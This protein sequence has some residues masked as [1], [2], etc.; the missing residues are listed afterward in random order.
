MSALTRT[1]YLSSSAFGVVLGTV[2]RAVGVSD[3]PVWLGAVFLGGIA[4]C[5][6][7][8]LG[9]YARPEP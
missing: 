4:S 5:A 2:D 6:P 8:L 1:L 3:L 7:C 9:V